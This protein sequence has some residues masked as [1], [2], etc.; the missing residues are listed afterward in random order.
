MILF[1]YGS[2]ASGGFQRHHEPLDLMVLAA[3]YLAAAML[4]PALIVTGAL[5]Y[6]GLLPQ[7]ITLPTSAKL[8]LAGMLVAGACVGIFFGFRRSRRSPRST[9]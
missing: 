3:F 6:F 7:P 4:W 5:Q 9:A 1:L 2:Y 8:W